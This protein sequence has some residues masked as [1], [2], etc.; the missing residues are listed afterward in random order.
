MKVLHD[1]ISY[2]LFDTF[3]KLVQGIMD[4]GTCNYL[5]NVPY[6]NNKN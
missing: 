4:I 2:Y 3:S 5:F 6:T 1:I